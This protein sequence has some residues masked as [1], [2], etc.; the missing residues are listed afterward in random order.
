MSSSSQSTQGQG[1]R[2]QQRGPAFATWP[3]VKVFMPPQGRF[4]PKTD[5]WCFTYCT[6]SVTGRIHSTPPSCSTVC[7]RKVFP[8]E[9]KNILS[10]KTH[11]FVD[12]QG[13]A[14]YVLPPEGQS[15]HVPKIFGGTRGKD[16]VGDGEDRAD[17]SS[18]KS[19]AN[20]ETRYWDTGYY[21]FSTS[22]VFG[23]VEHY[24][25]MNQDLSKL[26]S[27]Q[28]RQDR[29][30]RE[31]LEYQDWLE[32]NGGT[33]GLE[34]MEDEL[35]NDGKSLQTDEAKK[36]WG[37]RPPRRP[38]PDSLS[39]SLLVPLPP[40]PPSLLISSQLSSLLAPSKRALEL[41]STDISEGTYVRFMDRM[42]EKAGTR[43][44]YDLARRSWEKWMKAWKNSKDG[45]DKEKDL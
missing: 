30:K 40:S 20:P 41:L 38:G 1:Q 11:S 34:K 43:E 4:S 6:Q 44:P 8:H 32:R 24:V 3:T 7:I 5:E 45:D 21:L 42:W 14:K 35:F 2:R 10:F 39:S 37:H 16:V 9:V 12:N 33:E 17:S 36:Y 28:K 13:K 27:T 23:T 22:S 31:W 19:P 18:S 25:S 15:E 26:A 29:I